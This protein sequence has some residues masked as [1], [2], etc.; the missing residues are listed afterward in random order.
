[1]RF[2]KRVAKHPAEAAEFFG[3]YFR[4]YG[5]FVQPIRDS[6]DDI[7]RRMEE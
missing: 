3:D 1:V 2:A 5:R 7:L 6:L 4:K